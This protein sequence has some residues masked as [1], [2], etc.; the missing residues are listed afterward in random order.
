EREISKVL[1]SPPAPTVRPS[2]ALREVPPLPVVPRMVLV[3]DDSERVLSAAQEALGA[4]MDVA[5]A[6]RGAE[7]VRRWREHRAGV[8]V[9]ERAM[10]ELDGVETL[11]ALRAVG[12]QKAYAV[13]LVVRGDEEARGRARKAGFAA[14]VEKP[15]V[16]AEL[17]RE[18]ALGVA[19][20]AVGEVV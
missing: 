10:P 20:V 1:G 17:C 5:V 19:A 16:A 13:A 12:G 14:V 11:G 15:L 7:G 9:I 18:V 4:S 2:G 8:V 3:V 6:A